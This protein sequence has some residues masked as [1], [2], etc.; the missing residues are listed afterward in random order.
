MSQARY[1]RV[2]L[3]H[4]TDED[5]VK[6]IVQQGFN[7]SFAG[8][9]ATAYGKG[10]YFARDASCKAAHRTMPIE[11]SP[12]ATCQATRVLLN[13]PEFDLAFC[14]LV[15]DNVLQAK[16]MGRATYVSLQ[17]DGRRVLSR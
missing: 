8:K 3:F 13:T 12:F 2:W 15:S 1:E 14:R 17:G 11:L 5:T 16:Y 7:R 10:V 4:G 9:N 6:K